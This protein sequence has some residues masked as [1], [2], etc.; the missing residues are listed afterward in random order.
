MLGVVFTKTTTIDFGICQSFKFKFFRMM[1][2]VDFEANTLISVASQHIQEVFHV[3]LNTF[4][5]ALTNLFL[6]ILANN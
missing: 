3:Y 2:L 4:E 1:I 5:N 6:V